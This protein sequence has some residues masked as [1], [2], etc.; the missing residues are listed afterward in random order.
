MTRRLYVIHASG[1]GM[2]ILSTVMF[3]ILY[4]NNVLLINY[5]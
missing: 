2:L 3:K 4:V 5:D 1:I